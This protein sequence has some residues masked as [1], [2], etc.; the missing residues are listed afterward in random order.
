MPTPLEIM[1]ARNREQ[2]DYGHPEIPEEARRIQA[3][4]EQMRLAWEAINRLTGAINALLKAQRVAHSSLFGPSES[5][6]ADMRE[7]PPE[8]LTLHR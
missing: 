4:E 6:M 1:D 7:V 8:V 3:L 5:G 2:L